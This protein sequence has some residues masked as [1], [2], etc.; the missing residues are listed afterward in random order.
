[1]S[2]KSSPTTARIQIL[3]RRNEGSN[4]LVLPWPP[5]VNMYY[6]RHGHVMHIS[7]KGTKYLKF[8]RKVIG[9][10]VPLTGRLAVEIRLYPPTKRV[11]LDVDNFPKAILD[12][13]TKTKVWKD[14][15]QIDDLRIVRYP[16]IP[17]GQVEVEIKELE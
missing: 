7:S 9:K 10:R 8:V 14:D 15:S 3:K 2:P 11:K 17:L 5:S 4:E 13:L 12:S 1:M 6:R 16:A